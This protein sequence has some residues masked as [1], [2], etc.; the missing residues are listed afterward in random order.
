MNNSI[1]ENR[2]SGTARMRFI[3]ELFGNTAIFPIANIV[4]ELLLEGMGYLRAPDVYIIL[5]V[6]FLQA[7]YLSR[8][9]SSAHPRRFL[10]NFIGPFLY[11]VIEGVIEGPSCFAAAHHQAYWFFALVIGILQAV[12]PRLPSALGAFAL[13]FE[14]ITRASILFF[15]YGLFEIHTNPAQTTSLLT[16]FSDA[17]HQFIAVSAVLLGL[18]AGLANLMAQSHLRLLRQT[19]AQLKLYSEWL[20]GHNLLNRM[21]VNPESLALTRQQRTILFMDIR[22]FTHWSDTQ[23]PEEVAVL[24]TAY[25]HLAE[26][27]FESHPPIKFKFTADEVMAV[28]VSPENALASARQLRIDI[29]HLLVEQNLGVGIGLH[30]GV[31]AEGLLGSS[32]VKFY[33][34]IGDTVN[35]AKRIESSAQRNEILISD[36]VRTALNLKQEMSEKREI[37]VKGKLEPLTVYLFENTKNSH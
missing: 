20:L 3:L 35:V 7:Y 11:T 10:G 8:W 29:R 30:T 33:D 9:E 22:G 18:G 34:V 15:M 5:A 13:I 26:V 1:L 19:S 4:F 12:G 25:Y 36:T 37:V 14:N 31:V 16:F 27:V 32:G 23:P 17:S 21:V 28:F 6:T 24:L 2:I